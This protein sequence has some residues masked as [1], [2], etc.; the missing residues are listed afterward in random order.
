MYI[1]YSLLLAC[2]MVVSLPWWILQMLRHGK[3]RAG[4]AE[5]LGYVP[6]RL[7]PSAQPGAIWIH[8]V[9][10]GEVLAIGNLARELEHAFPKRPIFISTTTLTAQQLARQRYG[11]TR[12]F[13]L[14]I[15][16]GFAIRPYLDLLRPGMLI[17]AETEF[18]PNLLHLT[19]ARGA[20]VA[21][22]NAR[23]SD[24]SF[25][26]YRRFRWLFAR[27]L[28]N[29]DL[30]LAQ[31]PEDARRLIAIGA[32]AERVRV[33][34]NLK[35]DIRPSGASTVAEDLRRALPKDAPVIVCGSTAEGEEE[36]LLHAFQ[37][38]MEQYPAAVMILAPRHPER[39]DKVANLISSMGIGF[40]RRSSWSD[41]CPIS[42][43]VFLLDSV[44]EL[45]SIYRLADIAFVGGSL[46]PVGGHNIL[47][48]AQ[49]GV[50]VMT[51]PQTFNF[52]EIINI[53]EQ[54][55]GV[56]IVTAENLTE[57]LLELMRDKAQRELLG[58]RA[59]ELFAQNTGATEKTLEELQRLLTGREA[60]TP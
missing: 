47:E 46:V 52:R 49:Y 28:R 5:R 30:F 17:L 23:I 2:A 13:F 56:K 59:K 48:P 41:S 8:A 12:A 43:G 20:A 3:Y 10:V 22:V 54:G 16:M 55:G 58:Q 35:F 11:N 37:G 15:D 33:R 6:E 14:P 31:T 60:G 29:V 40:L 50:A 26:R 53:F 27:V 9:S 7:R 21:V 4:L 32:A 1:I 25:P 38:M 42:S 24:R 44:G 36:P 34:G 18:W 39:F 19:R 57:A 45:A 51:G